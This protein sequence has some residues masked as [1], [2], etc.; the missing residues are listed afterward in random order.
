MTNPRL[1]QLESSGGLTGVTLISGAGSTGHTTLASALAAAS[2][3]DLILVGP[4]T[5]SESVTIP[6]GVVVKGAGR[7]VTRIAGAAPTGVRVTLN[8]DSKISDFSFDMPTDAVATILNSGAGTAFVSRVSFTGKG[9]AG[10][11]IVNSSSGRIHAKDVVY[12]SGTCDQII[13]VTGT[14]RIDLHRIIVSGGTV[15]DALFASA[16]TLMVL[17]AVS[18]AA[19]VDAAVHVEG[20]GILHVHT[21]MLANCDKGLH[22]A[23]NTAELEV[24]NVSVDAVTWDLLIDPG[25]TTATV[26]MFSGSAHRDKISHDVG[27]TSE[28]YFHDDVPGDRAFVVQGELVVGERGDGR[29]SVFGEGDSYV[30]G[31]EIK[32]N[33]NLEIGTWATITAAMKSAVGSTSAAFPGVGVGNAIYFGSDIKFSGVKINTTIA[34]ALG[35]G[36]L[37]WEFW[38][39]TT[40]QPF[41]LM[42]TDAESVLPPATYT[43]DVFGRVAFEQVRWNDKAFST[44]TTKALDGSTRFWVRCRIATAITT[45]PTLEQ[46]KIHSNRS[47]INANGVLEFFGT[48][49]PL[50]S[51]GWH[52]RHMNDLVG[53][54][55]GNNAVSLTTNVGVDGTD[56]ALANNA[57][58]GIAAI[59]EIPEGLDTS[60]PIRMAWTWIPVSSSGD[61][62]FESHSGSVKLGDTLDGTL[63]DS[64]QTKIVT[65]PAVE[66]LTQ[67]FFDF[68]VSALLPGEFLA[69]SLFRNATGGNPDDTLAGAVTLVTVD[70]VGTFWR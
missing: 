69:V 12:A 19:G 41:N 13:S 51:L 61:V 9:A 43:Q 58:D 36:A 21:G 1:D 66:V 47:E 44:W 10:L 28:L 67:D 25:V 4:G 17:S 52:Q 3:G 65:A 64:L 32:T 39:S 8:S 26:R 5:Y 59:I 15:T 60:R 37:I 6:A 38:D 11:G 55:S 45:S 29:E 14:G 33:T 68:D 46:A 48:G 35:A 30:R 24:G 57:T 70:I 22:V 23:S 31:M 40:W 27:A 49:Q 54:L 53:A 63:S 50:R 56:N 7:S 16:G 2:S 62:E 18:F 34:I 20:T 42:V